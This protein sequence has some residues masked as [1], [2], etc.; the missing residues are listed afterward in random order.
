MNYHHHFHAGNSADVFKHLLLTVLLKSLMQ[1][2]KP[3]AYIDTH[4]GSGCYDLH[5]N[6]AQKTGEYLTGIALL[7]GQTRLPIEI[8]EYLAL[9]QR[10]NTELNQQG[11]RYYPGSPGF[12]KM[13]LRPQDRLLLNDNQ[14]IVTQQLQRGFTHDR[15][16][17]IS[18]QAADAILKA[19]LPP[20]ERRGLAFL[21]PPF[22]NP[23][24]F[25]AILSALKFALAKWPT[26]I[27]ACWYPIKHQQTVQGFLHRLEHLNCKTILN[28]TFCPLP[29]DVGQR[30][31]GS[32][33][34]ICNPP[35]QF[36]QQCRQF[37]PHLAKLLS[38]SH[39]NKDSHSVTWLKNLD[40]KS[41]PP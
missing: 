5:A 26:G 2:D 33:M 7:W 17:N 31:A 24:E 20:V 28:V 19:W 3:L 37:L 23:Q 12:A 22:E 11:L 25:D 8:E 1:K 10:F 14:K 41:Y 18:Q 4:A 27:Y 38:N 9:I 30:L 16:V 39:T 32:G 36:E 34:L 35:W 40:P 29:S 15:R 13:L 6:N 21:D